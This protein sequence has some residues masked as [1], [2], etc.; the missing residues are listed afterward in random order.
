[1]RL[2]SCHELAR[3]QLSS[4]CDYHPPSSP[5]QVPSHQRAVVVHALRDF[6][7][8][9]LDK[10][11]LLI[12]IRSLEEQRG[13]TIRDKSIVGSLLMVILHQRLDYATE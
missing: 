7:D 4:F 3:V 11:V 10:K 8:L 1:M 5:S 2:P 9:L 12:F 13:F 6:Q